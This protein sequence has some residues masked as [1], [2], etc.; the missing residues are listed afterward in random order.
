MGESLGRAARK[1]PTECSTEGVREAGH[2]V[3]TGRED[4]RCQGHDAGGHLCLLEKQKVRLAQS[5]E[6]E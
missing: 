5:A 3:F 6:G 4:C 1:D 2:L